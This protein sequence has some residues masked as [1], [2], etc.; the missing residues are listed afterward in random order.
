MVPLE[1]VSNALEYGGNIMQNKGVEC[2]HRGFEWPASSKQAV[3][4]AGEGTPRHEEHQRV[5]APVVN[6]ID[7][8]WVMGTRHCKAAAQ[9]HIR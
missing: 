9:L 2:A 8:C 4:D 5:N 1:R 6:P 7:G 3:Q